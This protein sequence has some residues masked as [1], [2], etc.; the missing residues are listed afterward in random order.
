VNLNYKK[1]IFLLFIITIFLS[2]SEKVEVESYSKSLNGFYFRFFIKTKNPKAKIGDYITFHIKYFTGNDSMFF[3]AVK[4][5]KLTKPKFQGSVEECFM[6]L[7][8]NDSASFYINA[9]DFFGKTIKAPLPKFLPTNSF[10][11]INIRVLNICNEEQ[12]IKDKEEFLSWINGFNDYEKTVIKNYIDNEQ[13]DVKPTA[14][15]IYKIKINEGYGKLVETK[16]TVTVHFEG[17]FLNGKIFDSTRKR[18]EPFKFVFGTEWQ[19]VRGLEEAIGGMSKGE[20][21]LFIMPSKLAFG[22]KGSSSG[23]IPPYTSVIFEVEIL[24]VK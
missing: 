17:R 10:F 14:S 24:D 5:I 22:D 1:S 19:V 20:K 12:F 21:A 3:D 15:G 23:I 6:M 16:D 9:D 13:I 2:C 8:N 18:N 4:S 7:G 11:K